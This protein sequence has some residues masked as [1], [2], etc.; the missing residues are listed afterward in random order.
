MS[1]LFF[2]HF[3]QTTRL[4]YISPNRKTEPA[5]L[6]A[7]RRKESGTAALDVGYISN[8]THSLQQPERIV[9]WA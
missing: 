9:K 1:L 3:A 4:C 2:T 6:I 8:Y 5:S 7:W